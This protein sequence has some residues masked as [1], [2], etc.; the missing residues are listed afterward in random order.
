[1]ATI[2]AQRHLM[3]TSAVM[4][5]P[6]A[7]VDVTIHLW[8]RLAAELIQIIGEGGFQSLYTR[9]LHLAGKTYPWLAVN[10]PPQNTESRFSSLRMDLEGQQAKTCCEASIALLATFIDILSLLIGE[11]LTTGILRSAWGDDAMKTVA[12]EFPQ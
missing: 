2:D 1:M 3:I 12:K 5:R 9:S 11:Q 7:P 6:D 10:Q 8:E 4:Q